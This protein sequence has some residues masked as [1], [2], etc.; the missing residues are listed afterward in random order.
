[1][2]KVTYQRAGH[3]RGGVANK[4]LEENAKA[5]AKEGS[6]KDGE[7]SRK[8]RKQ[9]ANPALSYLAG[10]ILMTVLLSTLV[11]LIPSRTLTPQVQTATLNLTQSRTQVQHPV[12]AE[13]LRDLETDGGADPETGASVERATGDVVPGLG[14]RSVSVAH[15][16]YPSRH[17]CY[18]LYQHST[19]DFRTL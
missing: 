8:K 12:P 9:Y 17:I 16:P 1:M 14:R 15:I 5:R 4:I 19:Y 6:S 10:L 18:V 3:G 7:P 11:A 2:V 13:A